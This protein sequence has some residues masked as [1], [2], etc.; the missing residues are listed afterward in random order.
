M[1]SQVDETALAKILY[2]DRVG[3]IEALLRINDKARN[4][5]RFIANPIQA[6]MLNTMTGRD[7]YVKPAQVGGSSIHIADILLDTICV[8]G[9]VSV[10]ISYEEFITQRLL[11]KADTFYKNLLRRIP[12]IPK[13][14][15]DSTYLKTFPEINSSIYIGSARSYVFGRGE[16]IHNLLM[17]EYAFWDPTAVERITAPILDRVPEPPI[18]RV[19]VLSTPN[20]EN[21]FNVLYVNARDKY[22]IGG[23]TFKAHFY[24][25]FMHSEYA[26]P[27]GGHC[28][29]GDE[30]EL[31]L[32]ADEELLVDK[33]NLTEDQLRWRRY[34]MVEAEQLRRDGSS[35]VMFD[36]EYPEDDVK[37]FLT[38]G[39]F[40]YEIEDLDRLNGMVREPE[41]HILG[42][43]VWY[44]PEDNVK[45]YLGIDPG[46]GRKSFS[47]ATVWKFH[48]DEDGDEV[49]THCATLAGLYPPEAMKAK[50]IPLARA[51]NHA[52]AC[53]EANL[54]AFMN[55]L[56]YGQ[57]PYRNV[58]VRKDLVSG[59][60]TRN[61]GWLT[62][63]M[64]KRH[65]LMEVYRL[66][67]K[68]VSHDANFVRQ[69]RAVRYDTER[70]K[71]FVLPPDD[72]HDSGAIA[73][74]CRDAT[75]VRKGFA[76][77][78]GWNW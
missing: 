17:D 19:R 36:Q 8:P 27:R 35:N 56:L 9:T 15:A 1:I 70:A 28:L 51:Y 18:G 31:T 32:D 75:H 44:P 25:W 21:E 2:E 40:Y 26:I 53:P 14:H 63:P 78:S 48:T 39:D 42:A 5:V 69:L 50:C 76:G 74:V 55:L 12:S 64:T 38:A 3:R 68:M 41:T 13:M 30:G 34:K 46:E 22:D 6:D 72:F 29:K 52:L 24:P 54:T 66:L 73:I 16:N 11:L 33:Y 43:Q 62:T 47:V 4:D 7:I 45:Y 60:P 77:S 23:S 10:I 65:M 58:Y 67:P 59:Y 20:G 49:A 61:F 57:N 71:H 37:C